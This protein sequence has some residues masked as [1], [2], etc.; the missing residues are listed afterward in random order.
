MQKMRRKSREISTIEKNSKNEKAEDND[1]R[2]GMLTSG[3]RLKKYIS[4]NMETEILTC[5]KMKMECVIL[6]I[7]PL[8]P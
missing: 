4:D 5:F 3:D 2:R 1:C 8:K 7:A 6:Q